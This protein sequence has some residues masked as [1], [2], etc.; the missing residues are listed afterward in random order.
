MPWLTAYPSHTILSPSRGRAPLA[1]DQ[2]AA[3][4]HVMPYCRLKLY[5]KTR[6]HAG[7]DNGLQQCL[8][9]NANGQAVEDRTSR[10]VDH[11]PHHA[12]FQILNYYPQLV[13]SDHNNGMDRF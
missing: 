3:K 12:V 9:T 8:E 10:C 7:H 11:A 4:A 5:Q 1:T 6:A 2:K 13:L